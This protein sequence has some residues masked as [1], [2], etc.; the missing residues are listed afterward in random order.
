MPEHSLFTEPQRHN[1][2]SACRAGLIPEKLNDGEDPSPVSYD[3]EH[4]I[5]RHVEV[6]RNLNNLAWN[7]VYA[8]M[9][10]SKKL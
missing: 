5:I 4:L 9:K 2:K 1:N 10:L 6:G 7:L 3:K 8:G